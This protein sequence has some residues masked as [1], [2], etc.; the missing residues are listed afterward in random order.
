[1]RS[2]FLKLLAVVVALPPMALWFLM[3]AYISVVTRK[4]GLDAGFSNFFL[5]LG[6]GYF[7]AL[8]WSAFTSHQ[9]RFWAGFAAA[10]VI[11]AVEIGHFFWLESQISSNLIQEDFEF[12]VFVWLVMY[13]YILFLPSVVWLLLWAKW[14]NWSLIPVIKAFALI[15]C[16]I[17]VVLWV[18]TGRCAIAISPATPIFDRIF[19]LMEVVYLGALFCAT[20][21]STRKTFYRA[22]IVAQ[23]IFAVDLLYIFWAS[24]FNVAASPHASGVVERILPFVLQYGYWLT[25]FWILFLFPCWAWALLWLS[26]LKPNWFARSNAAAAQT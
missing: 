7:I 3:S 25:L 6:A 10:H 12:L 9:G 24:V 18:V 14:R 2:A 17:G 11:L 23:L 15:V 1:M 5:F 26:R 8:I 19:P 13:A 21:S 20:L 16:L 22:L 4:F